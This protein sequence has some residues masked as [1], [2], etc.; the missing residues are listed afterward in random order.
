LQCGIGKAARV[1]RGDSGHIILRGH[2]MSRDTRARTVCAFIFI[3]SMWTSGSALAERTWYVDDD[4]PADFSTI[5]PALDAASDGDTIIVRDG[6]YTGD[7][8]RDIDF[9]GKA[10]HLRSENGP[11]GCIIDDSACPKP[12]A[13][14]T[15]AVARQYAGIA[16]DTIRCSTFVAGVW[17]NAARYF[18]VQIATYKPATCFPLGKEDPD[19]RSKIQLAQDLITYTKQQNIP[20]RDILF[21]SWYLSKNLL[22]LL[23]DNDFTWISEAK[24]TTVVSYRRKWISTRE[25]VK[26]IPSHK[27]DRTVVLPTCDGSE[28]T[29]LL[30]SF[31]TR[32]KGLHQNQ[33]CIVAV[34]KWDE[35]DEKGLHVFLTNRLSV[36][37][38][39]IVRRYTRRWRIE[40]V[41]KELKD[42]LHFDQYQVRS[43]KAIEHTWHLALLAHTYLQTLQQEVI[44]LP[45]CTRRITL[46]DALALHRALNDD[47]AVRWIRRNPRLF[48]LLRVTD[49]LVA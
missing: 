37:P 47:Q 6:Y 24:D 2:G 32:M 3:V 38:D 5:Q 34:G 12:Y 22:R 26:A 1:F 33:R 45:N 43:M 18:P 8:N 46:G 39:E 29:F 44:K 4:W 14:H 17:A 15:E 41:F 19:F 23:G 36:P 30:A 28:R 16:G 11:E 40:D 25:L 35:R 42:F 10:V 7:G 21:D 9:K 48:Q 20:F 31:N 49:A 13:F 27:F